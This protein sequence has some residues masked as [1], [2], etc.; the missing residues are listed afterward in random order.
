ME[1]LSMYSIYGEVLYEFILVC[2]LYDDCM[3]KRN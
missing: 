2:S 3:V 1:V